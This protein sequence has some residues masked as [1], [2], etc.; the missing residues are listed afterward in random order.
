VVEVTVREMV[1]VAVNEPEVPVMVT[2]EVPAVAVELAVKVSTLVLVAGLVPNA[3]VTPLGRPEAARVTEP[4]N[5]LTSVTVMVSLP[6][7]PC[8]ID[9]A[10]ADGFS[11][12]L[13]V[14]DVTVMVKACVL[15][16]PLA[17]V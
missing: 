16:Q 9:R 12:K 4:V 14:D 13:P 17:L 8:A 3:A 2:V 6:L 11:V 15:L 5:G 10:D 1:V 7:A